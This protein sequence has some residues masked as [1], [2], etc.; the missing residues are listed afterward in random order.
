M[1]TNGEV[2]INEINFFSKHRI[3]YEKLA[4]ESPPNLASIKNFR[5]E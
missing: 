2:V 5:V 3:I 4:K 1:N